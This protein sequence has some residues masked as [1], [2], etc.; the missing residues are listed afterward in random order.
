LRACNKRRQCAILRESGVKK[1]LTI[2][3]N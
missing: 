3:I 2:S 1:L